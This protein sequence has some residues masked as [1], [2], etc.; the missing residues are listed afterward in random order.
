MTL[1]EVLRSYSLVKGHRIRCEKEIVNLLGLL[2]TQHSSTLEERVN[3]HLEKLERHTLQL[4]HITD[5]LIS[6]K[7]TKARDHEEEVVEFMEVLDRCS[8]DVFAILHTRHAAAQAVAAPTQL[9]APVL[10]TV[11]P[12][13]AELKPDKLAHDATMANYRTWM[14]QFRAYFDAGHVNTLPCAQ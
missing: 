3:D 4:S 2:N 5:Y 12:P 14:K 9:V 11:K 6:V 8:T 1:E 7:Y 10:P 13:T